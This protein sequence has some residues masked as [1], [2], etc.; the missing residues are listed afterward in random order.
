MRTGLANIIVIVE[1]GLNLLNGTVMKT[2]SIVTDARNIMMMIMT[3]VHIAIIMIA[4][5]MKMM[6][7][8]MM[9]E[10]KSKSRSILP[11]ESSPI[12]NTS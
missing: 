3:N 9:K 5:M 6:M 12:I 4:I 2:I 7:K 1:A 11:K 8:M 10:W